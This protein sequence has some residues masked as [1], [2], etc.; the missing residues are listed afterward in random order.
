MLLESQRSPPL[1]TPTPRLRV[2][3]GP[4][5]NLRDPGSPGAGTAALTSRPPAGASR[6]GG[7][8]AKAGRGTLPAAPG[9]A[10]RPGKR[11]STW[12]ARANGKTDNREWKGE[13]GSGDPRAG[14]LE[15][16]RKGKPRSCSGIAAWGA[17]QPGAVGLEGRRDQALQPGEVGCC[18]PHVSLARSGQARPA[19]AS[20]ARGG[21]PGPYQRTCWKPLN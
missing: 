8:R 7:A 3:R 13:G 12:G 1:S 20:G 10:S 6:A 19:L 17:P 4:A 18:T 16:A 2:L 5:P 15:G 11:K 14:R 21:P 9:P